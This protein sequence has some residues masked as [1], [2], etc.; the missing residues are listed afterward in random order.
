[1]KIIVERLFITDVFTSAC[2]TADKGEEDIAI[3]PCIIRHEFD[4]IRFVRLPS[5][6]I[7]T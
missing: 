5:T 2:P 3:E 1:V 4:D 7:S 6:I